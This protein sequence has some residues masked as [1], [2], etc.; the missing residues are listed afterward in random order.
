[1]QLPEQTD[2][3][4]SSNLYQ[5][6]LFLINFSFY[7]NYLLVNIYLSLIES[8]FQLFL[9]VGKIIEKWLKESL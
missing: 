7:L 3:I 2:M 4:N 5:F 6:Y 1:M 8:N 9:F